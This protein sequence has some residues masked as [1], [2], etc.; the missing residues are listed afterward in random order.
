M[1]NRRAALHLESLSSDEI[2]FPL[3][4]SERA[5]RKKKTIIEE[6]QMLPGPLKVITY[7]TCA[8]ISEMK[9]MKVPRHRFSKMPVVTNNN[10][11]NNKLFID[12]MPF[13]WNP[14]PWDITDDEVVMNAAVIIDVLENRIKLVPM[15]DIEIILD[16]VESVSKLQERDTQC[17]TKDIIF[18][19][20][21]RSMV[22][23]NELSLRE[24]QER[25]VRKFRK[26]KFPLD[27]SK[28]EPE[29]L[30]IV[31]PKVYTLYNRE[32]RTETFTS[33]FTPTK[34]GRYSRESD[35]FGP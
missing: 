2:I 22:N 26:K 16:P 23:M 30:N 9:G 8:G 35:V 21:V 10:C 15:P 3:S 4:Y 25:S 17:F 12:S 27:P 24:L 14:V 32:N 19:N 20:T 13:W 7:D 11:N 28:K 6:Q 29:P 1:P 31:E 33:P 18:G 5:Q 34:R